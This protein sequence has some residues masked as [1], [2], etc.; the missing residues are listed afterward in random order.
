MPGLRVLHLATNELAC[1]F[2][3]DTGF[4]RKIVHGETEIVRAI[5]A[6]VRDENWYTVEPNIEVRNARVEQNGFRVDFDA[7]CQAAGICFCWSGSIEAHG[8][9]LTFTFKGE[10]RSSFRKN[11]IGFCVLHPIRECAALPCLIQDTRGK[12]SEA[13]FP[14]YISPHQ[15]F[16]DIQGLRWSPRSGV[17][18]QLLLQ[19]SGTNQQVL[20]AQE[21]LF[22][23]EQKLESNQLLL[24]DM[25]LQTKAYEQSSGIERSSFERHRS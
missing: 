13:L 23:V 9:K 8:P 12:W 10:A 6:A 3:T 21:A 4:L 5:Y 14:G 25:L 19:E 11:R 18:A 7:L 2:E 15:P 1:I 16:K 17:E 20:A 22:Q 24:Q